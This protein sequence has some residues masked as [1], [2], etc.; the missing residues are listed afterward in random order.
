MV[1]VMRIIVTSFNRPQ[2]RTATLSA[3]TLPQATT[4]PRLHQR[5]LDTYGQVWVRLFWGHCSFRLR[6]GAHK[7]LFVPSKSLF[8]PFCIS[9]GSSVVGLMATSSKKAYATPRS[10]APRAP[11][12]AADLCRRQVPLSHRSQRPHRDR[13]RTVSECLLGRY[14]GLADCPMCDKSNQRIFSSLEA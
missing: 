10:A 3:P 6:P 8:P 1:G 2:A 14:E 13:D 12:P 11:A 5:L 7:F 9:S 4:D